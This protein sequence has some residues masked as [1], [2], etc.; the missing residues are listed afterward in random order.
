[1]QRAEL[2]SIFNGRKN[3]GEHFRVFPLS[4]WTELDVWQYMLQ[5]KLDMPSIYFSHKRKVFVRNGVFLADSEFITVKDNETLEE[6][7]VRFRTI[8]D[9]TCT[10]AI[11]S[12][13][14]S[15]EEVIEE[16]A[17][18]R[19]AER[20]GRMDDQRTEASMEDRKKE[21]YF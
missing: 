8:G 12:T 20:G 17:S 9:M 7:T 14:C 10:G 13:A 2:W 3:V 4:N 19:S 1:N 16:V 11:E 6:K 18:A 15:I 21:G 5:E